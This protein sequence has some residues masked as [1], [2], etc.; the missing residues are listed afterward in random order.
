MPA[1]KSVSLDST[2]LLAVYLSLPA[3]SCA[4]LNAKCRKLSTSSEP[5]GISVH[6]YSALRLHGASWWASQPFNE[7]PPHPRGGSSA[8][9]DQLTAQ[10]SVARL[11]PWRVTRVAAQLGVVDGMS[12]RGWMWGSKVLMDGFVCKDF[13]GSKH[14]HRNVTLSKEIG[15][16]L[17]LLAFNVC[18]LPLSPAELPAIYMENNAMY[19]ER[20]KAPLLFILLLISMSPLLN[21]SL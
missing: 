6:V 2:K 4:L 20:A 18:W 17:P 3:S 13:Y 21:Y 1:E 15:F 10:E 5:C 8:F 16:F 14:H 7:Q 12:A 11:G 9:Q 19:L